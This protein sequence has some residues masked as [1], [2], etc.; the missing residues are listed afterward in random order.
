MDEG[1][2]GAG[3][4]VVRATRVR[5]SEEAVRIGAPAP[6]GA[7][8]EPTVRVIREGDVVQ[9]IEVVCSCGERIRIRCEY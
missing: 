1:R 4:P 3:S 5:V 2:A 9:A 6:G 7:P 8:G